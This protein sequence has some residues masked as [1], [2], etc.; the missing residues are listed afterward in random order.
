I[1]IAFWRL[2][3]NGRANAATSRASAAQ[4]RR[5][6]SRW[7]SFCRRTE[8]YGMRCRN[9][10]DGNGTT[11]RRS[12]WMRWMTTGTAIATRP[13]R[14]AGARKFMRRPSSHAQQPLARREVG[15]QRAVE[16]LRGVEQRVVGARFADAFGE[17]RGMFTYDLAVL[18]AQIL[19]DDGHLLARLQIDEVAGVREG[20]VDLVR[21][22]QVE[23][24]DVVAA[25]AD[26]AQR[27]NDIVG[28]LVKIG[29]E[30]DEAAPA[31]ILRELLER[32]EQGR[33]AGAGAL[34]APFPL[35]P[36]ERVQDELEVLGRRRHVVDDIAVDRRQRYAVALQAREV[37]EAGREITGVRQLRDPP[38][39]RVGAV[40][41]RRRDVQD[42]REVGVG[43]RLVLLDV[44]AVAPRVEPPVD[45]PDV[46]ARHVRPMLGEIHRRA[47]MR[48]AMQTVDESLD[49]GAREQLEVPDPRENRGIEKRRA[50]LRGDRSHSSGLLTSPTSAAARRGRAFL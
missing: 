20:E 43:I 26:L 25:P 28:I 3:K 23:D 44:V 14:N 19:G 22:E 36:I 11:T 7:R 21:V 2:A 33:L 5:S 48:R 18:V 31:Q 38:R 37:G 41:H 34:V 46:V 13:A 9:I 4:R 29:D 32:F 45:A 1:A 27:F 16:R 8:R 50:L 15:E 49:D 39:L 6:S 12:R 10:S 35:Q 30:D 24:D 40:A 47:Q 17:R 42:H